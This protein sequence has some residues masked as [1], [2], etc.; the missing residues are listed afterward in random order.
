[1]ATEIMKIP[2]LPIK[3][4]HVLLFIK[5]ILAF[6]SIVYELVL[7]QALAAFFENTVLR[8]SVTIGLYMLCIGLGALLADVRFRQDPIKT[9]LRVQLLL[10]FLGG[11]A[12]GW[13]FLMDALNFPR[14]LFLFASHMLI[15]AIG[16][17][18]GFEVPLLIERARVTCDRPESI[19]LA[20]DYAGAF[21]GSL[22]FAF[23]FYPRVGLVATALFAGLGNALA[24][25]VLFLVRMR[26]QKTHERETLFCAGLQAFLLAI[27][28]ICLIHADAINQQLIYLYI[29]KG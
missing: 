22:L 8:Y 10:T 1:M 16:I 26:S 19:T 27:I 12:L 25:V 15:I 5:F 2:L 28:A 21:V 4:I 29:S 9:L 14:P 13:F 20:F 6:C 7:A 3:E 17:L 18:T 23:I 11:F 24:G